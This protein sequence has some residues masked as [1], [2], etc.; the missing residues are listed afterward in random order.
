MVLL[1]W[2]WEHIFPIEKGK[3]Y[4]MIPSNYSLLGSAFVGFI[5][6]NQLIETIVHFSFMN[7]LAGIASIGLFLIWILSPI[8]THQPRYF[9]F[10]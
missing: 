2:L 6:G 1:D 5:A 4:K 9:K 3:M 7:L 10:N 8:K